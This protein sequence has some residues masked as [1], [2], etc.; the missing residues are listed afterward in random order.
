[1]IHDIG[2][3]IRGDLTTNKLHS[4]RKRDSDS[5]QLARRSASEL[6]K[7]ESFREAIN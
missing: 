5:Y 7:L 2:I 4:Y 3:W 6:A 1:M